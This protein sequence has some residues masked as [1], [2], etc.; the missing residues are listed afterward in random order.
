LLYLFRV[1]LRGRDEGELLHMF[2]ILLGGEWDQSEGPRHKSKAYE[3]MP[4]F[5]Y[6]HHQLTSCKTLNPKPICNFS[7]IFVVCE[8]NSP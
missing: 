4:L 2:G 8:I 6:I 3:C 5:F 1:I 7:I